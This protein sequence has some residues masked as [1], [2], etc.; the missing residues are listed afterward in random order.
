ML[1]LSIG[2]LHNTNACKPSYTGANHYDAVTIISRDI[3]GK[4][5]GSKSESK[6]GHL[7][8]IQEEKEQSKSEDKEGQVPGT[9][10]EKQE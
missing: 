5:T 1:K 2:A 6:E 4:H 8:G 10:E 3:E 9:Q 7:E